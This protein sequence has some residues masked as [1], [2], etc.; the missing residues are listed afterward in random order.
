MHIFVDISLCTDGDFSLNH[1]RIKKEFPEL[2]VLHG[3][4]SKDYMI[5]GKLP[6]DNHCKKA[7][8]LFRTIICSLSY[9]PTRYYLIGDLYHLFN[10][11]I[12]ALS[13]PDYFYESIGGNYH[14]THIE[15]KVVKE[16]EDKEPVDFTYEQL[17]RIDEVY[18]AVEDMCYAL[19]TPPV[20][21]NH[22]MHEL[23]KS[24]VLEFADTIAEML[25]KAGY[26]VYFPTRETDGDEERITDIY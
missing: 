23:K 8:D 1:E 24:D 22:E 15:F 26:T 16:P 12:T 17:C 19:T 9:N 25:T 10:S 20:Y 7:R 4:Y 14:G 2:S 5:F 11:A 6:M 18:N 13:T 21:L 3:E